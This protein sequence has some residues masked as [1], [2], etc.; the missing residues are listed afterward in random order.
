MPIL[1]YVD[2]QILFSTMFIF[3]LPHYSNSIKD[4]TSISDGF[5]SYILS[6]N[7]YTRGIAIILHNFI[8]TMIKECISKKQ[9]AYLDKTIFFSKELFDTKQRFLAYPA[10]YFDGSNQIVKYHYNS[11]DIGWY[12]IPQIVKYY[13]NNI[14]FEGVSQMWAII[15]KTNNI[16]NLIDSLISLSNVS[17]E[18]SMDE[19]RSKESDMNVHSYIHKLNNEHYNS[20]EKL[21]NFVSHLVVDVKYNCN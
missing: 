19:S 7:I 20:I 14:T 17:S 3:G 6:E 15:S 4:L 16:R 1:K 8:F 10:K 5:S 12:S 13:P 21:S 2:N 18:Q 11:F 9:F